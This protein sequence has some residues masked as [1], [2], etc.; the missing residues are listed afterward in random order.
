MASSALLKEPGTPRIQS[1]SSSR[2]SKLT[3]AARIPHLSSSRAF[4][5]VSRKPL[6]T[7]PHGKPSSWTR[8]P[9][10]AK[11]FLMRGSPPEKISRMSLGLYASRIRSSTFSKSSKGMSGVRADAVQSLPQCRQFRLQRRVHSQN[12]CRR[13]CKRASQP[14]RWLCRNI[15]PARGFAPG[16]PAAL[17]EPVPAPGLPV[18]A[19]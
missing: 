8:R 6:V 17:P 2:P 1:C 12:S 10:C 9:H 18:P 11:S 4:W 19:G 13:G 3:V 16:I 15:I 14:R 5:G 7:S